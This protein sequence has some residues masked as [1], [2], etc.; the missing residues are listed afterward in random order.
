MTSKNR[1]PAHQKRNINVTQKESNFIPTA[2]QKVSFYILTCF[3]GIIDKK[4]DKVKFDITPKTNGKN[5]SVTYGCNRF[6]DSC[7]FLSM[8][9][10]ELVKTLIHDEFDILKKDFSDE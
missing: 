9:L 4:N 3:I 8:G 10:G 2:F 6:I 5:E 1:G 7:R